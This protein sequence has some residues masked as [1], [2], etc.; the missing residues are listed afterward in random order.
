MAQLTRGH[1]LI[2]LPEGL[3]AETFIK[4][5]PPALWDQGIAF[6]MWSPHDDATAITIP[7]FKLL[8]DL[9]GFPIHLWREREVI[10]AVSRFGVYLGTN[11]PKIP[12]ELSAWKMAIA[13]DDLCRIPRNIRLSV[14]GIE[15]T[16]PVLPVVWDKG[17]IYTPSDLPTYPPRFSRPHSRTTQPGMEED[18]LA[19]VGGGFRQPVRTQSRGGR[20]QLSRKKTRH[21]WG[22]ATPQNSPSGNPCRPHNKW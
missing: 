1:F 22:R 21:S 20:G 6:Q 4:A 8:Q 11:Q 7:R 10:K 9:V 17:P 18:V 15:Y 3:A 2:H 5:T 13:T 14:G 16:V 12:A 19:R